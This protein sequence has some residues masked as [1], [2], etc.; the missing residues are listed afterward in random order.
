MKEI[1]LTFLTEKGR[2]VYEVIDAEGKKQSWKDRKIAHAVADDEVVSQKPFV[3]RI[4]IK[5]GWLAVQV[6]LD[7]QTKIALERKGLKEGKDFTIKVN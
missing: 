5:I 2:K 3:V 7:E 1:M 6:K 4:K